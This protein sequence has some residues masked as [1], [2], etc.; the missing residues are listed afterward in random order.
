MTS[1]TR[2]GVAVGLVLVVAV[3]GC[4]AGTQAHAAGAPEF[5]SADK[6]R[7]LLL[8]QRAEP[9][10]ARMQPAEM[11]AKT[12]KALKATTLAGRRTETRARY[13][14]AV[15]EFTQAEKDTLRFYVRKIDSVLQKHYPALGRTP[16]RFIK[17]ADHIE[18]ML[19]HTHGDAIVLSPRVMAYF[20][21]LK[22]QGAPGFESMSAERVLV[23]ELVH[24]HQRQA[25]ARYAALYKRWG[26]VYADRITTHPEITRRQLLNPDGLDLHWVYPLRGADGV[27]WLWP[28]VLFAEHKDKDANRY[29]MPDDFRQVVVRLEGSPAHFRVAREPS[30][31]PS[32]QSVHD[33]LEYSRRFSVTATP[34]HPNEIA[35]NLFEQVYM[36]SHLIPEAERESASYSLALRYLFPWFVEISSF[37]RTP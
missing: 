2:R 6:A 18:G 8:T 35:A 31:G 14:A 27:R 22:A 25:R 33:D 4:G 12:G 37:Y 28:L 26:F 17:L 20:I 5:L 30:G 29:R 19:P 15:L 7:A 24:V 9:Y 1:G 21:H 11:A 16:W 36:I 3:A 10:F 34:Y 32:I 23:H 13:R